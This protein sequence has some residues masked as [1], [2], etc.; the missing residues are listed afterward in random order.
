MDT[1]MFKKRMGL[2]VRLLFGFR[3]RISRAMW[4]VAMLVA[5]VFMFL[6]GFPLAFLVLPRIENADI[7]VF[8]YWSTLFL[9]TL[10]H[11][12]INIKRLHDRNRSGW[13]QI[14]YFI[15]LSLF[16]YSCSREGALYIQENPAIPL[17]L[18]VG[19]IYPVVQI[20]FLPGN[21]EKNRY[22]P[23]PQSLKE[24]WGC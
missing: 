6:V 11:F 13:W 7:V 1:E 21:K 10:T 23:P 9:G 15:V 4:W 2:I 18:F 22:G 12:A 8:L 5:I 19:F 20:F 24:W 14:L 16:P 17:L 3:G